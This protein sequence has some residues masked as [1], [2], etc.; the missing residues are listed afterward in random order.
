[1]FTHVIRETA[2]PNGRKVVNRKAGVTCDV[3]G[4]QPSE[5]VLHLLVH[6]PFFEL[7]DPQVF[8]QLLTENFHE[9]ATAARGLVFVDADVLEHD[10]GKRIRVQQMR[11]EARDV[12]KFVG[13]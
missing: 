11:K 2:Q 3:L 13:F 7:S 9:N 4:E 5:H 6:E 12:A 8:R 1:V 10:P